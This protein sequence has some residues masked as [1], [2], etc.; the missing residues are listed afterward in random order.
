MLASRIAEDGNGDVSVL[1]VLLGNGVPSSSASRGRS[2]IKIKPKLEKIKL[3]TRT[4]TWVVGAKS[5]RARREFAKR[6]LAVRL[7][8]LMKA[9]IW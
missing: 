2:P 3:K 1:R 6:S 7:P 5:S 8:V 4:G 9:S